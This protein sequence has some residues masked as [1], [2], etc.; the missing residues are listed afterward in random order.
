MSQN[1]Q[2]SKTPPLHCYNCW[3]RP[4]PP[5]WGHQ[6][7]SGRPARS[8]ISGGIDET[9]K[10]AAKIRSWVESQGTPARQR[11]MAHVSKRQDTPDDSA[12][13]LQSRA[14]MQRGE[15]Y[16]AGDV[17]WQGRRFW[18]TSPPFPPRET[19]NDDCIQWRWHSKHVHPPHSTKKGRQFILSQAGVVR[20]GC[21]LRQCLGCR[22]MG[23][24]GQRRGQQCWYPRADKLWILL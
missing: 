16:F 9:H 14:I 15:N 3:A 23:E 19:T 13:S 20:S 11:Y 18:R 4:S 24:G 12:Q 10:R 2:R 8:G 1:M 5:C 17:P 22:I 7:R 21:I 6:G